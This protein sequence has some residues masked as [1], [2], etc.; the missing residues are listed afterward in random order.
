MGK[1]KLETNSM[2]VT[3]QIKQFPAF[4]ESKDSLPCS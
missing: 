1:P 4:M 3:Q 2:A